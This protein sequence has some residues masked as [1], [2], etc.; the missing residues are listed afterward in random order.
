KPHSLA[1]VTSSSAL[2]VKS[3]SRNTPPSRDGTSNSVTRCASFCM[4]LS[5]DGGKSIG[6]FDPG[7]LYRFQNPLAAALRI[8]IKPVQRQHPVH[9]VD[10]I[11][12]RRI[13]FRVLFAQLDRNFLYVSPLHQCFP[14]RAM[15][16]VYRGISI[17]SGSSRTKL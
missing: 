14:S 8:V 7:L 6:F 16:I 4:R 1:V 2:P 12:T 17:T 13:P 3:A 10:E 11:D 9:Q 15:L 5:G